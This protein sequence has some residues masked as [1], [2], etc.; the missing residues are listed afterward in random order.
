[1]RSDL[2]FAQPELLL[3]ILAYLVKNDDDFKNLRMVSKLFLCCAE[4]AAPERRLELNIK[5]YTADL[6]DLIQNNWVYYKE[7]QGSVPDL[8]EFKWVTVKFIF[9]FFSLY[10]FSPIHNKILDDI[11]QDFYRFQIKVGF[12]KK[13]LRNGRFI[14]DVRQP[15]PD[16]NYDPKVDGSIIDILTFMRD[17]L[18][19]SKEKRCYV[20]EFDVSG[21]NYNKTEEH[22]FTGFDREIKRVTRLIK[23]RITER[24]AIFP[25]AISLCDEILDLAEF[26]NPPQAQR[27]SYAWSALKYGAP[28]LL[29]GGL[30]ISS[31]YSDPDQQEDGASALPVNYI[32]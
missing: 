25:E 23:N 3:L 10:W 32:S 15:E 31:Y 6:V 16:D 20:G 12:V 9:H 18:V 5:R 13:D 27:S 22:G 30:A 26:N 11:A 7:L 29:A 4:K 24:N 14:G 21:Q 28:I 17:M 19:R 8:S 2:I 1:M